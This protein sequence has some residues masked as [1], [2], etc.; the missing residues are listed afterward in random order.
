MEKLITYLNGMGQADQAAFAS[1]CGTTVG[2]LRKAASIGQKLSDGLCLRVAAESSGAVRPE[3]LR[4]DVDWHYLR[5]AL[6]NT[7]QAATENVAGQGGL[8]V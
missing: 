6:A 4:S 5:Q 7:A 1:R 3:D 2:Y 8:N